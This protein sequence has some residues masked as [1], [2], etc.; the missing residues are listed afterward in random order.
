MS[1][2]DAKGYTYTQVKVLEHLKLVGPATTRDL[3]TEIDRGREAV[4]Q[5]VM[6]LH[7]R[8]KIY[9]RDWPYT[10]VQRAALWA[11]R[12]KAQPDTPRPPARPLTELKREWTQRHKALLKARRS[13]NAAR[14]N[15]FAMLMR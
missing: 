6:E 11:I 14:G 4:R 2:R 12:L 8:K 5:A 9:I 10:G 13:V 7:E 15:P 1:R 3:Y